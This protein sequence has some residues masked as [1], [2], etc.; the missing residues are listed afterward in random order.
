MEKKQFKCSITASSIWD[1][2]DKLLECYP[3]LKDFGFIAE[4]SIKFSTSGHPYRSDESFIF[5]SSLDDL[6]NLI[7]KTDR[8][9]IQKADHR[10]FYSDVDC[11]IEIYDGW[12]E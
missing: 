4:K 5:I 11:E 2:S 7:E 1:D 9:I 12:R 6:V 3:S 10:R 8:V